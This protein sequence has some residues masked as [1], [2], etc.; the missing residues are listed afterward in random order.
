ML[1]ISVLSHPGSVMIRIHML[2][3]RNF[4][5]FVCLFLIS[6]AVAP[7]YAQAPSEVIYL[8]AEQM[9]RGKSPVEDM[10]HVPVLMKRE[11]VRQAVLIIAR[12]RFGLATRDATLLEP[13]PAQADAPGLI[14]VEASYIK[15]T[16]VSYRVSHG[17]TTLAEGT[18]EHNPL[19]DPL[20]QTANEIRASLD[21][22]LV[23][24][25]G[26]LGY[27]LRPAPAQL[28][29]RGVTDE[30]QTLIRRMDLAS[31]YGVVRLAHEA[32]AKH[33]YTRDLL[34]MLVRGYANLASLTAYHQD[35]T[36]YAFTARAVHY[37]GRLNE[38][39]PNSP[40]GYWCLAYTAGLVGIGDKTIA[41]M[42]A[43]RERLKADNPPLWAEL[44]EFSAMHEF[45]VLE[46]YARQ[47]SDLQQL[48][49]YLW[50][51]T[52]EFCGDASLK[53]TVGEIVR[54]TLPGTTRVIQGLYCDNEYHQGYRI[55][56]DL[57]QMLNTQMPN[58]LLTCSD[59]VPSL[60]QVLAANT[61]LAAD[62]LGRQNLGEKL[63]ANADLDSDL[64]EPSTAVLGRLIAA[65][66]ALQITIQIH[67]E[68]LVV[69]RDA[70]ALYNRLQPAIANH[71]HEKLIHAIALPR[72]SA[73][74]AYQNIL[75]DYDP[76]PGSILYTRC[77]LAELLPTGI[78]MTV[79]GTGTF[80]TQLLECGDLRDTD[81]LFTHKNHDRSSEYLLSR[82]QVFESAHPFSPLRQSILVAADW[83]N[84]KAKA[85][86]WEKRYTRHPAFA[87][88]LG[89]RYIL[90]GQP[91]KAR[92]LYDRYLK[93]C[94][95]ETV[96]SEYLALLWVGLDEK[97]Q[98][99]DFVRKLP[100]STLHP[101][102]VAWIAR[103]ALGSLMREERFDDAIAFS[104]ELPFLKRYDALQI[105][106]FKYESQGNAEEAARL[107]KQLFEEYGMDDGDWQYA[108][109]GTDREAGWKLISE[110]YGQHPNTMLILRGHAAMIH[111][112]H[113]ESIRIWKQ[114][115]KRD[116]YPYNAMLVAMSAKLSG[117]EQTFHRYLDLV[118]DTDMRVSTMIQGWFIYAASK[119]RESDK[120]DGITPETLAMLSMIG[121]EKIA[122]NV[123]YFL[124]SWHD[125]RGERQEAIKYYIFCA[126]YYE[127]QHQTVAR[128][129]IRL[130]ELGV[131]TSQIDI[132]WR[133]F[134]M[135]AKPQINAK[136]LP[137]P[138]YRS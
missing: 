75:K 90:E 17:D 49:A 36:R 20:W 44:A 114:I 3:K 37:A 77:Y 134:E 27:K 13:M 56:D 126:S 136:L 133:G 122:S 50:F 81:V 4:L 79:G 113:D 99:L 104:R 102:T 93:W 88:T 132:R 53:L 83:D 34:T 69:Q 40:N 105:E 92:P 15:M 131:D 52:T 120:A 103:A 87:L 58:E 19:D 96:I 118:T 129:Y 43:G 130:R 86:D 7:G 127:R 115:F 8:T 78:K 98:A 54:E 29:G 116:G 47:V 119:I 32:I 89:R 106:M 61:E 2:Y 128:A 74:Q 35:A 39:E 91:E 135:H 138:N 111:G 124:A 101:V 62:P 112:E 94:E 33:G 14:H 1:S 85:A 26:K 38:L 25:M 73:R 46:E 110:R 11:L 45:E 31:Q 108:R 63:I 72:N 125:A 48:A 65:E 12:D 23:Q 137:Y 6:S 68:T 109:M 57:L 95:S 123:A 67:Y 71:P 97:E 24:A 5:P 51:R 28:D 76:A 66:N 16:S 84:I 60:R 10:P 21:R 82:L 70:L 64:T 22:Q 100:E 107:S 42:K 117:D 55:R 18:I 59:K 121:H 41:A 30:M 9:P 80:R